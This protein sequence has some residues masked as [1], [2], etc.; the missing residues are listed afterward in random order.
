[1]TKSEVVEAKLH[2][3]MVQAQANKFANKLKSKVV[4]LSLKKG[5]I[6]GRDKTTG[7][8]KVAMLDPALDCFSQTTGE[9]LG[10]GALQ[11]DR[12]GNTD[13]DGAQE[14]E[15]IEVTHSM[16]TKIPASDIV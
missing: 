1:M 15:V 13:V 2:H 8:Y 10:I 7:L 3:M 9:F 12:R 4:G 6:I 14:R 5:M 11:L 16:L